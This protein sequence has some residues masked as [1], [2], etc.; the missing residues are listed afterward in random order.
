MKKYE[1]REMTILNRQIPALVKV[2][3]SLPYHDWCELQKLNA[4]SEVIGF[5]RQK[6]ILNNQRI[7][8]EKQERK[9]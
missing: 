5:L 8:K 1:I 4:W 7:R 2:S 3:F 6:E 9:E